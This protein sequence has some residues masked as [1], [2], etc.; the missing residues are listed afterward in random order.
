MPASETKFSLLDWAR[1]PAE[2]AKG[3]AEAD[4]ARMVDEAR[5]YLTG[6]ASGG[7]AERGGRHETL[8]RAVLGHAE[9]RRLLLAWIQDYCL[10]RRWPTGSSPDGRY[11][12]LA[13]A[14]FAEIVGFN[15]LERLM[16]DRDGLEEIQVI[17]TRIYEVRGG[18]AQPSA[19]AFKSVREVERLQQ[20]L[21][22]FNQD[23]LTV[24]KRWAEVRLSDGARVTMTGFGYTAEPTLTIRFFRNELLTLDLL[25]GERYQTLDRRGAL[26]LR[27]AVKAEVN[28]VIVGPT[29]SGKTQLLKALVAEM[30]PGERLVTIESR[31]ELM[32]DRVFPGRNIIQYEMDEDDPLHD[33]KQAF[34]LAL[35][36]SPKR[37]VLAEIRDADANLYVRACTRGHAGSMTTLHAGRLED[38]P[39]AIAEMC[40]QDGRGLDH[41]RLVRRIAA[42]VTEIG[43]EM[44]FRAGKRQIVRIGEYEAGPSGM[45]VRTLYALDGTTGEWVCPEPPSAAL[46]ARLART[47]PDG[48][49]WPC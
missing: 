41:A 38:V 43:I 20:N 40:L 34:K 11:G 39:D 17:G 22:L 48:E 3:G 15:I 18:V 35:R 12:S 32:L 10:K 5:A 42:H 9:E 47:V 36:Q 2:D 6:Y 31:H 44:A 14:V 8:N 16:Q 37:I 49:V 13:E 27:A 45:R 26:L 28:L 21:V 30:P 1:A 25:C 4:F 23:R 29:N 7:G 33:G 24:R 46:A 19:H